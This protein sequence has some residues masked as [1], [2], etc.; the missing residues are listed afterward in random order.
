MVPITVDEG[1]ERRSWVEHAERWLRARGH[2]P[3]PTRLAWLEEFY[4]EQ[5][6][7]WRQNERDERDTD[8]L[9]R[10]LRTRSASG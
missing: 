1:E 2:R 7:E 9:L 10:R 4:D 5:A 3:D 8:E 6:E